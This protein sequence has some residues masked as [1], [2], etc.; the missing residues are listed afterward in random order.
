MLFGFCLSRYLRMG[1]FE[2]KRPK[3]VNGFDRMCS[4]AD[5]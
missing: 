1:Q 3:L 5:G 4:L 2:I